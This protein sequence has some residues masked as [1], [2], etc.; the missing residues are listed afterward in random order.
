VRQ[1]RAFLDGSNRGPLLELERDMLA[2]SADQQFERAAAL[3]D[4]LADLHWLH[5]HLER[6]RWAREQTFVYP[7]KG[8]DGRDWWYL[9]RR[10]Q[11]RAIVPAAGTNGGATV[12]LLEAVFGGMTGSRQGAVERVEGMMLVASWFRK[13]PAERQRGLGVA[14]AMDLCRAASGEWQPPDSATGSEG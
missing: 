5:E 2:A 3:R 13:R 1:A 8:Y 11:V 4:R 14:Q 12:E 7:L 9:L 10:G 6:L